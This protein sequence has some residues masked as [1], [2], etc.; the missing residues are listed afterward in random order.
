MTL[1]SAFNHD[2]I[3]TVA[4]V[5]A[6]CAVLWVLVVK[7][8]I[9]PE[10]PGPRAGGPSDVEASV[11]LSPASR[12]FGA[13]PVAIVE[14]TDYECPFCRQYATTT[15]PALK[16]RSDVSYFSVNFPLKMHQHAEAAALAA[17]CAGQQ[18]QLEA[19][20]TKLFSAP[21]SSEATPATYADAIG[22]SL[23]AYQA[24]LFQAQR[25]LQGQAE[26]ARTLEVSGTPT[27]FVGTVTGT[28]V[29][30]KRRLNG[31]R[32]IGELHA[33]ID[34]VAGARTGQ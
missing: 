1:K 18:G 22:V 13:G 32:S 6:A 16:T 25:E 12:V 31:V 10:Q 28:T 24:C 4:V 9:Q 14:F 15:L 26:M 29:A 23:E 11:T 20:H 33:E 19:M 8:T 30:L 5:A 21:L 2:N 34:R 17:I 27:L 7:P 3:S